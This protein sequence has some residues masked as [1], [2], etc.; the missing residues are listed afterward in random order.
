MA[1]STNPEE[2]IAKLREVVVRLSQ[3]ESLGMVAKPIGVSE[4]T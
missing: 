3:D 2:I 4:Q 1:K